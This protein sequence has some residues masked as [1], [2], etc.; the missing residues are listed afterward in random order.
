MKQDLVTLAQMDACE[1]LST[2]PAHEKEALYGNM[3][4]Q[5]STS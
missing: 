4:M 1:K 2:L 3:R 5:I